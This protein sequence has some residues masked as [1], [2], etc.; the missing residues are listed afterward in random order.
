VVDAVHRVQQTE[1]TPP[2]WY[3]LAWLLHRSGVGIMGVRLLSLLST[4]AAAA[5]LVIFARRTLPLVLAALSGLLVTLGSEFAGHSHELR[6][7]ALL[8]FITVLFALALDAEVEQ[9]SFRREA[10]LAAVVAAGL[11]THYFFAFSL[12]GG[13]AWLWWE[14]EARRV[15]LRA[16][17]AALAGTAMFLPWLPFA[18]SQYHRDRFWWIG[19]FVLRQ[20]VNTPFRI[21][22][23]LSIHPIG[24]LVPELVLAATIVGALLLARGSRSGRL[25][26][27][28]ALA[29]LLAAGIAWWA[30]MRIFAT[31]NLL[32]AGPFLAIAVAR[33]IAAVPRRAMLLVVLAV[34][35]AV[36]ASYAR[37][38][39]G[40]ATPYDGIARAL[41]AE[42]WRPSDPI[43]VQGDFFAFRLPLEWYLPTRPPLALARPRAAACHT[44]FVVTPGRAAHGALAL[45]AGPFTVE[46]LQVKTSISRI[47]SE[48]SGATMTDPSLPGCAAS[49][50][51]GRYAA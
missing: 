31:R 4:A 15:R 44:L 37:S 23:P 11:F 50:T 39:R 8:L 20:V 19:P 28:L 5:L 32:E 3:M 25:T 38:Q 6:A 46:R 47:L 14:P 26:A 43:T 12:L 17:A 2:L 30:G 29:P 41:V 48:P 35:A 9:P 21:F 40:G 36:V 33:A 13:L 7:Y 10:A 16:G 22:S 42:G 45:R 34:V 49:V 18:L 51:T 27:I 24:E 1:S